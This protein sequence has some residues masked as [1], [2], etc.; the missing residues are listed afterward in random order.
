MKGASQEMWV[1]GTIIL[2]LIFIGAMTF[3][4]EAIGSSGQ[5]VSGCTNLHNIVA[6]ATGVQLC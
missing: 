4:F 2:G 3:V 5:A 1:L 6:E